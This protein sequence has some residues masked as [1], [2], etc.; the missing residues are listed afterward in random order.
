MNQPVLSEPMIFCENLVKIYSIP[1]GVEV[2]ALQGL[3]LTIRR[4]EMVGLVGESGSGKSTLLNVLGG[5]DHPSAGRVSVDGLD[6]IKLSEQE[7]DRYRAGK[8]GFLW[9]QTTRNLVPYLTAY[10]NVLLPMQLTALDAGERQQRALD[11]LTMVGLAERMQHLPGQLSGGEQQR[12]AIAVALANRPAIL[13]ADEPTGELDT[14][15]AQEIY[16]VLKRVN[17]E[18]LTTVLIVSHDPEISRQV[19]RVVAIRDGKTSMET[20]RIA[21]NNLP[22]SA[23]EAHTAPDVQPD[24]TITETLM[25]DSAGRLQIPREVLDALAVDGRLRLEVRDETILLH[26]VEGYRKTV[27]QPETS[28]LWEEEPLPEVENRASIKNRLSAWI[29]RKNHG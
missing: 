1:N 10:E 18:Y 6:L 14:A 3:D 2:I 28:V 22:R 16:D 9:Q 8:V 23:V 12:T 5:L 17:R 15:T 13:L 4:G 24:F 27:Q 26:P 29:K 19:D 25:L 11:L 7:L 21:V 20:M